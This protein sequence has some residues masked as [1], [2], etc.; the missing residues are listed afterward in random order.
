M[1]LSLRTNTAAL[2]AQRNFGSVTMDLNKSLE[3]LSSGF[4]LNKA[5]DGAGSIGAADSYAAQ[6]RG[7]EVASRNIQLGQS[8][9]NIA[10]SAMQ[11]I[12]ED[13][14]RMREVAV[15]ASSATVTDFTAY[16]A[17]AAALTANITTTATN[18]DFNGVNLIGAGAPANYVIQ[19]GANAADTLDIGAGLT[20]NT[21]ATL[22][23]AQAIGS[24]ANAQTLIGEIDTALGALADNFAAVGSQQNNLENAL[25][26]AQISQENFA[27][28]EGVLRNTDVAAETSRL[29]Q[30]QVVQQASA[31]ALSQANQAPNIA[32]SLLR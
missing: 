4:R 26:V 19:V 1:T 27:A 21:A 17:E 25:Q 7:S 3:R 13:L 31:L 6:R 10:D 15:E 8:V 12:R 24:N 20:D 16:A 9:L 18:T 30:M 5:G 11:T 28:A 23:I 2:N 29:T 22:G 32:L 14:L